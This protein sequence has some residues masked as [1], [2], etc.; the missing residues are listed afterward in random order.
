MYICIYM[1]I[2][3]FIYMY[4]CVCGNQVWISKPTMEVIELRK[5][6]RQTNDYAEEKRLHKLVRNMAKKDRTIWLN[7][8][9]EAGDWNQV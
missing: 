7:R 2:Y 8:L 4:I 3:I 9:L 5:A 1:D 6:A